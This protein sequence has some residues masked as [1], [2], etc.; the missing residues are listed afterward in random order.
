VCRCCL[1]SVTW[2]SYWIDNLG[3]ITEGNTYLCCVASSLPLQGNINADTSN[4]TLRHDPCTKRAMVDRTMHGPFRL[5]Q[6]VSCCGTT[7]WPPLLLPVKKRVLEKSFVFINTYI[8][9]LEECRPKRPR[10]HLHRVRGRHGEGGSL[11]VMACARFASTGLCVEHQ[12]MASTMLFAGMDLV[13]ISAL[14][15]LDVLASM[16]S[17]R[18]RH[19]HEENP[20]PSPWTSHYRMR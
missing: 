13:N 19:L 8:K 15:L 17:P 16:I 7:C 3:F 11:L 4:H 6:A 1:H 2:F 12:L 10:P 9:K 20:F 14:Q 18:W 5:G